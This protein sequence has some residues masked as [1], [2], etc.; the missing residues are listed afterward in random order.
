MTYKVFLLLAFFALIRVA[1]SNECSNQKT[2]HECLSVPSC[3]FYVTSE[4]GRCDEVK[5]SFKYIAR[6]RLVSSCETGNFNF[7][8]FFKNHL[9]LNI[10]YSL[11]DCFFKSLNSSLYL[12]F[13]IQNP[14]WKRDKCIGF[15][16]SA[17]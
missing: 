6:A 15:H 12:G 9:K 13:S 11:K 16:Q 1:F 17:T 8:C 4:E 7:T 2:C 5:P 3:I 14:E 10:I